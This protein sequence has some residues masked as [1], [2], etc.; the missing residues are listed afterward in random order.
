MKS[1]RGIEIAQYTQKRRL[2][3]SSPWSSSPDGVVDDAPSL[4]SSEGANQ[5]NIDIPNSVPD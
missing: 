4:S 2:R 5:S 3:M 1:V